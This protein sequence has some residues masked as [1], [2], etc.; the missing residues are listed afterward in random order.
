[1]VLGIFLPI[2]VLEG[3]VSMDNR[4][5]ATK[6]PDRMSGKM[7]GRIELRIIPFVVAGNPLSGVFF[8]C[9]ERG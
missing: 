3:Q 5:L 8:A 2:H 7:I 6:Q 1:M 9:S 4:L